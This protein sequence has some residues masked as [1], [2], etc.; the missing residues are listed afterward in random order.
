MKDDVKALPDDSG[1]PFGFIATIQIKQTLFQ[2]I[3][4]AISQAIISRNNVFQ[5]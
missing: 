5:K 2:K 3:L 4:T 1:N